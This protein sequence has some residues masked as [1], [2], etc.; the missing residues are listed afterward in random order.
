MSDKI[1]KLGE[2]VVYKHYFECCDDQTGEIETYQEFRG[3]GIIIDI[4]EQ[5]SGWLKIWWQKHPWEN[6][7]TRYSTEH[8]EHYKHIFDE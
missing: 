6:L 3:I 4:S 2:L 8:I 5:N 7:D 1:F